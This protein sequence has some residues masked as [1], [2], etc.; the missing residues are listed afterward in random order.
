MWLREYRHPYPSLHITG[1]RIYGSEQTS[2]VSSCKNNQ[3]R[4]NKAQTKVTHRDGSAALGSQTLSSADLLEVGNVPW[5][6]G[7]WEVSAEMY[8]EQTMK[9]RT[10]LAGQLG[11]TVNAGLAAGGIVDGRRA[12]G[13]TLGGGSGSESREGRDEEGGELHGVVVRW[14]YDG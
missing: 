13:A 8:D 11:N 3:Y 7:G 10:G 6:L 5:G 9:E 14:W 2:P 4:C 1:G 12:K